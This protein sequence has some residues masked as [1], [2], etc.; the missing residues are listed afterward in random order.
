MA[1]EKTKE[2]LEEERRLLAERYPEL[3]GQTSDPTQGL[4]DTLKRLAGSAFKPDSPLGPAT[5]G[6]R[7]AGLPQEPKEQFEMSPDTKK[8]GYDLFGIKDIAGDTEQEIPFA[9][10][11]DTA[12]PE[13]SP[14]AKIQTTEE[15]KPS[16]IPAAF[17][18]KGRQPSSIVPPEIEEEAPEPSQDNAKLV[19]DMQ[20]NQQN[21]KL[22]ESMARTRDAIIGAGAGRRFET[23]YGMYKDLQEEAA[24]PIQKIKI[25][26]ELDNAQ[27]KN[28]PN[29]QLSKLIRKS[30]SELG[31]SMEGMDKISYAQIEKL[32]P[33]V[34]NAM[35]TK[36]AA[37]ARREEAIL[38]RQIKAEGRA[39]KEE[40]RKEASYEKTRTIVNNKIGKLQE[41]KTS[42][43]AGYNQAKQTTQ[44]L[45]NAIEAWDKDDTNAKIKNSVAFMQY[46]KL[47]QGDD[48]VVRSSDMQALAGGL[49]YSSP[50]ALLN[51]FAAKAE[52]SS[53]TKEEL[54]E[55]KK[56]ID[57]VRKVKKQQLQ[58]RLNPIRLD[59]ERGGYDLDQSISPDII[60][61]IYSPEPLSIADKAKRREELLRKQGK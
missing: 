10:K 45:D 49:N 21:A 29:S 55:M 43:F 7:N 59:A 35:M 24:S 31:V 12:A 8:Y 1:F 54:I 58:E 44:M 40:A 38:T 23:D 60:E 30:L 37:E 53:F 56:V 27:A 26:Q 17:T 11:E 18:S 4:R 3:I 61:E 42:P 15:I 57:T 51:K 32:Y 28:D 6:L 22:A 9:P 5:E 19:E 36:L 52:G 50:Y 46:A 2:E 34:A 20:R 25:I 33:S 41:A 39:D 48:S 47:A 14:E 16:G 13:E